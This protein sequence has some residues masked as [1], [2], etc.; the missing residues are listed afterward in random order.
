MMAAVLLLGCQASAPADG[1]TAQRPPRGQAALEGWLAAGSHRGWACEGMISPPRLSGNHGR[2]LICANDLLLGSTSGSYPV[3]AASVK[4]LYDQ[5][6]GPN[7]F[8]VGLKVEEGD[9]PQSW[10]WYE[11]RGTDPTATPRAEG[12]AVPDCAVC[13]GTAARDF[14]FIRP[15]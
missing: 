5:A 4:E 13:H 8:A 15:R 6:D 7:G 2:Q 11:R 14:V 12:V 9:G 1:G 10:Y 3:G